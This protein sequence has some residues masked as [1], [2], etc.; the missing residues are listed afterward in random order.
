SDDD[1]H[2]LLALFMAHQHRDK[3]LGDALGGQAHET[4][5]NA[6]E[7]ANYQV[8]QVATPWLLS[9]ANRLHQSLMTALINGWAEAATEQAPEAATRIGEWRE[10][11]THSV[12]SGEVGIWVGHCDLLATPEKRA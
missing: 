10:R 8:E 7:Q 1:D 5:V 2:W 9:S 6:L 11:R 4:L 3:G 12:A